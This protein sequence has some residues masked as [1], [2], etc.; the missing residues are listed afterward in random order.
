M[1]ADL[2]SLSD[3]DRATVLA[4]QEAMKAV[5]ERYQANRAAASIWIEGYIAGA[6]GPAE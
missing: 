3:H 2:N 5:P 6:V 1:T 4:M